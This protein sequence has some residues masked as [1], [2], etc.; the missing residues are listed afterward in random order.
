MRMMYVNLINGIKG[1]CEQTAQKEITKKVNYQT[2]YI[3][4]TALCLGLGKELV[5]LLKNR[6]HY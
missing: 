3:N 1:N 5:T 4:I 6:K 2:M